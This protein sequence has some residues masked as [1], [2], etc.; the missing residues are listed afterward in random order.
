[1]KL[2]K[3]EFSQNN[4]VYDTGSDPSERSDLSAKYPARAY[5][6]EIGLLNWGESL[7]PYYR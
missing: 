3:D 4:E 2:I 5:M 6:L 1:M 7:R